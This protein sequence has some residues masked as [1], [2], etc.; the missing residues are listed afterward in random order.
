ML[1]FDIYGTLR[2][3]YIIVKQLH[4][5]PTC[6]T[7]RRPAKQGKPS[8]SWQHAMS[9]RL[10]GRVRMFAKAHVPDVVP[11]KTKY[12]DSPKEERRLIIR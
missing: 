1:I 2:V 3:K 11:S 12:G 5:T 8:I 6:N 10:A 9:L 4:C 7:P